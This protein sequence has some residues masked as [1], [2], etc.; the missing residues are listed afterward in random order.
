[1]HEKHLTT[2]MWAMV[3]HNAKQCT[4]IVK[5]IINNIGHKPLDAD[6][7]HGSDLIHYS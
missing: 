2:Y 4:D 1:M 6:N 5:N 3:C 7:Y